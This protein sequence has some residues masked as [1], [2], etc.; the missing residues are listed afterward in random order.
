MSKVGYYRVPQTDIEAPDD[1]DELL[2]S[3][4]DWAG[5]KTERSCQVLHC[6]PPHFAEPPRISRSFCFMFCAF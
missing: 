4:R 2:R 1:N 5:I 6:L 3:D